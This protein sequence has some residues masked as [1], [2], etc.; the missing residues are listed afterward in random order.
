MEELI[1]NLCPCQRE[2]VDLWGKILKNLEKAI[3]K[4]LTLKICDNLEISLRP[5]QDVPEGI[6]LIQFPLGIYHAVKSRFDIIAEVFLSSP[7]RYLLIGKTLDK[8]LTKLLGERDFI[9]IGIYEH[10]AFLWVLLEFII[11]NRIPIV[12]V[13]PIYFPSFEEMRENLERDKLDLILTLE[14]EVSRLNSKSDLT[15]YL[16][17]DV[18]HY[19]VGKLDAET[20]ESL[21]R[22]LPLVLE[23]VQIVPISEDK[24]NFLKIIINFIDNFWEFWNAYQI[25]ETLVKSPH[26][27]L[28]IYQ[29]EGY[30]YANK[31]FLR[32]LGYK[33]ADFY[34]LK[35]SEIIYEEGKKSEIEERTLKRLSG[36]FFDTTYDQILLKTSDGKKRYF[37]VYTSTIVYDGNLS[38]VGLAIDVH[39]RIRYNKF[40]DLLR[41]VNQILIESFSE[42]EIFER[43]L[44]AVVDCLDLKFAWIG[45]VEQETEKLIPKYMYPKLE[46]DLEKIPE[47]VFDLKSDDHSFTR[48]YKHKK[49]QI[50][51]DTFS[52]SYKVDFV[53]QFLV[54]HNLR[55]VC[56]IPLFRKNKVYAVL[57]LY[58]EEPYFFVEDY[59]NILEELQ[60]DIAFALQKLDMIFRVRLF[61]EFLKQAEEMV[62]ICDER[63]KLEYINLPGMK[64]LEPS[65]PYEVEDIFRFLGIP[66]TEI[67]EARN[68]Q[69]TI[70]RIS[71][72]K[73]GKDIKFLE[74]VYRFIESDKMVIIGKD[75]TKDISL[76]LEK[77]R[78]FYRDHLTGLP[79]FEGFS[80]KVSEVLSFYKREAVLIVVD[81]HNF[82]YINKFYGERIGDLCLIEIAKRLTKEFKEGLIGRMRGDSFGIVLLDQSEEKII[83]ILETLKRVFREPLY[84]SEIKEPVLLSFNASLVFYPRDGIVFQEL[85]QNSAVFLNEAKKKG[86]NVVEISNPDIKEKTE[87]FF[88]VENL[89]KRAFQENLFVF[90]YQPIL[91]SET[92][93]VVGLEALVRI[94]DDGRLIHPK[95]FIDYI[96]DTAYLGDFEALVISK[97]LRNIERFGL[98]IS[99]NLSPKYIA[100]LEIFELLHRFFQKLQSLPQPLWIEITERTFVQNLSEERLRTYLNRLEL[101]NVRVGIDDFGTG[102]SFLNYLRIL[103]VDFIKI[104]RTFIRDILVDRRTYLIVENLLSLAKKLDIKVIAEGIEKEEEYRVLRDLKCDYVQGFLF[105]KPLPE[106]EI[107][108]FLM[109]HRPFFK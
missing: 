67:E 22:C 21:N 36:E 9:K 102:Y 88:Q 7:D 91:H 96:E 6:R 66:R 32:K 12:K 68:T 98:P 84:F 65:N 94:K 109:E 61:N 26:V 17:K 56:S 99:V 75:L 23:D 39:E 70:K 108:K 106:G 83:E 57:V 103:P 78:V 42:T 77:E 92:L 74:L 11:E 15:V 54:K 69:K 72:V 20:V 64:I 48:A 55:S 45:I 31:L 86:P 34:K 46:I 47:E 19:L 16:T 105:C 38:G 100:N 104:D 52:Y 41:R 95:E 5:F 97:S 49:I 60:R 90:H 62:I 107:E 101:L 1:F 40:L 3:D 43:I 13:L 80:K 27:G 28:F 18:V 58:S 14:S 35:I 51:S 76:Q 79:N 93:K 10:R 82:S 25:K 8:P 89:I 44:P 81:L 73:P 53:R 85:W 24:K 30:I 87:K 29:K 63:G 4:T 59:L 50:I 2:R 33:E 37:D 71:S